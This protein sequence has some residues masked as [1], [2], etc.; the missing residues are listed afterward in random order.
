VATL[1]TIHVQTDKA[2]KTLRLLETHL[3]GGWK[4]GA[5]ARRAADRVEEIYGDDFINS[6][7]EP[8]TVFAVGFGEAGWGT[9]HYNSFFNCRHLV[10]KL[11]EELQCLVVLVIAQSV[12]SAYHI[13]VC[14]NGE[15]LRTLEFADGEWVKNYGKPLPFEKE[16]L[17][18][19]LGTSADPFYV[20][21]EGDVT[22]YCKELGLNPWADVAEE[23]TVLSAAYRLSEKSKS[24]SL[25]FDL[26]NFYLRHVGRSLRRLA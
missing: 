8:P 12:S 6:T 1:T 24:G 10:E 20:F 13:S 19:N 21:E 23:W 25:R 14:R 3:R 18:H 15:H 17:G 26:D 4:T 2:D 5:I 7:D 16:P 11:S 22:E 9:V